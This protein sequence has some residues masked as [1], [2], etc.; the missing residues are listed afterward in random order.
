MIRSALFVSLRWCVPL[1]AMALLSLAGCGSGGYKLA[2]VS[3]K[4]TLDNKPLTGASV[5]FQPES[6]G[7]EGPAGPGSAAVTDAEGKFVL[8]TAEE[9]RRPGAVV[10]KH[11]VRITGSQAQ[12]DAGDDSQRV[13]DPVPPRYRDPGLPFE[14][15]SAGTDKADFDLQSKPAPTMPTVPGPRGNM[16]S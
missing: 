2:P 6:S 13:Q 9:K 3:G 11:V 1:A 10:G 16:P 12:R 5:A 15:P 4:V 8:Q 7:R 14:V